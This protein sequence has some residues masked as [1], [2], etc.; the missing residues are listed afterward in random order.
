V[1]DERRRFEEEKR[2]AEERSKPLQDQ[3]TQRR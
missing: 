3:V 2:L 1:A